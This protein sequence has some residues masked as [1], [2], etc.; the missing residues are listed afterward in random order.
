MTHLL[1]YNRYTFINASAIILMYFFFSRV[2]VLVYTDV[3]VLS[4]LMV[5]VSLCVRY[6]CNVSEKVSMF[7]KPNSA[8]RVNPGPYHPLGVTEILLLS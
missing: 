1:Y 8:D 6:H 2:I 4:N 7:P 3:S 5:F